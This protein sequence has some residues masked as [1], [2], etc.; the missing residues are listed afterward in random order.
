M[1][2]L[3][4]YTSHYNKESELKFPDGITIYDTTLR[5]GEQTP[6]VCFSLEDKLEIARKLDKIKINQIEAGFPIVSKREKE[7]V[8]TIAAEGLDADILALTRTK[9]EDIDAALDCDVDGIIT[10]VGTSDIHLDHKMHMTRQ[11]AINLC[12]N[13]VDYAKDHGLYVAFSAE[14]ATRTDIDFLK[15][16]YSKAE[17]CGADRVHIADTTG[18]ITPQ[19]IQYLVSE[20]KK[21]LKTNIALHCHNDFGLAVINSIYGVLAGATHVSTTVN[22]IGERAGNASLEELI[23]AL[24]ILYGKDLG[25]KTKYIKELSDMVSK[26]SGL[27]IPYNKPVVGN[28]V[29][30]HESGIHVDAVIEEPLCYEPYVPEL[31]GQKRQLVLGKHSGCRAVRAKLNECDLEVSD[32]ELIEIVK[33]VKKSREEGKYINDDVFKD[34]VKSISKK[35]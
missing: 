18:A 27:P 26:A 29:F 6:G 12:E 31:V 11:D 7:S 33:L 17:E 28:N 21:D 5:D 13:A 24:K 35:Q 23:M 20:L 10:F 4:Y 30:R 9:P 25:F 1:I 2:L 3:Q 34:I 19:G 8:S 22:G 32:D 15:R 16:I 14:D